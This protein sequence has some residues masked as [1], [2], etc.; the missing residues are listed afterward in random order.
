MTDGNWDGINQFVTDLLI[1]K[2]VPLPGG[3]HNPAGSMLLKALRQAVIRSV[4][5]STV[6][7]TFYFN[8]ILTFL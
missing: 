2:H 8:R 5:A 3:S 7:H 6:S 1:H 4:H